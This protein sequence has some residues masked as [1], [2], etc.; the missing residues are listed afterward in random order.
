MKISIKGLLESAA[1]TAVGSTKTVAT[2]AK[3]VQIIAEEMKR[4]AELALKIHE[5]IDAHEKIIIELCNLHTENSKKS[6]STVV[7][8]IKSKQT[9]KPN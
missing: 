8:F 5:R 4:L 2:L 6:A 3:A 1:D 7:D 9:S